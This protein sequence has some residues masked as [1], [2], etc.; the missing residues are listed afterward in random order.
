MKQETL[1]DD[2]E[3]RAVLALVADAAPDTKLRDLPGCPNN[4]ISV[5]A[6]TSQAREG[7]LIVRV[8]VTDEFRRFAKSFQTD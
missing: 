5:Y 7:K 8:E 6:D 4:L 3:L 1:Y 2:S